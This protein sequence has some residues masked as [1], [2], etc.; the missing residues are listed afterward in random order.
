MI[1][2]KSL[3]VWA[4]SAAF[5]FVCSP[6]NA[7]WQV[8]DNAVAIGRGTGQ[9][10]KNVPLPSGSLLIGQS[11][12]PQ[13][14][15]PTG[16][17][18]ISA[19]GVTAIG[20]TKVTSAMLNSNVY[21]TAHTWAGQQTFVAPI[22]GTPA[23]GVLTN[24]TGLPIATGVAGLGT[25][26]AA[27]LAVNTGS[28]GA[29]VLF[30][31]ALGTPSSGTATN[32]TGLPVATGISGL[33]T[34]IAAFLATPSSANLRAAL[35]DEVGTGSAYFVGGAL[36]T[37]ASGTATNLTG[38]PLSGLNTQAAY[39]LVGNFT[40]SAAVPTASTVGAL[41]LKASPVATDEIV[42][43]DNAASGA[44]K[45][46][47]V[48]SIAS[49]GS[50]ASLNGQTGALV[51][52][53]APQGRLTLTSGTPVMTSSVANATTVY[54]SASE[55]KNVPIYNGTAVAQY[56][57]CAANTLGPC[58]LSVA[59]AIAWA[60]FSNYDFFIGLDSGT[61]RLCTGPAWTSRTAR[62]SGAG[63]T[64]LDQVD[65][66][67]ANKVSMTCRY[68]SGSTFTCAAYQCTFVGTMGTNA[69][70]NTDYVFGGLG[71]G[72]IAGNFALWNAYNR[73]TVVTQVMDSTDSW[74]HSGGAVWRAV[75]ASSTN[76]VSFVIG[77]T[78]DAIDASYSCLVASTFS[79]VQGL[80]G[81]GLDSTTAMSGLPSYAGPSGNS[82]GVARYAAP[83]P[84]GFH[85]LSA[86]EYA[87]AGSPTF[88][89]DAGSPSAVQT[90]LTVELRL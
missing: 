86:L 25:G 24:A 31:G 79:T 28:A 56:Q 26:I 52:W 14:I 17:V 77:L 18:T 48:S 45:R 59:L 8:P 4:A 13:A 40:G 16:D 76:R 9:G 37:P 64:E 51:G 33:G 66:L 62:G 1:K 58:Q 2:L 43:A 50:V 27:A 49:A 29:P 73:V 53:T 6:A 63:T 78:S 39:S 69:S 47:S 61:V 36:G 90:G 81:V 54:Y 85:F 71:A 11:G 72:G 3:F 21:S 67:Y 7:Q 82:P 5:F 41:T 12:I 88:F 84:L 60:S 55:G 15:I 38:L 44:L 87:N 42:L 30:N 20:A 23:S 46:A 68:G 83:S 70:G 75:N 22:L 10:F 57:I 34:N 74:V 32:I 65:G 35:T 19:A 80:C 89:G